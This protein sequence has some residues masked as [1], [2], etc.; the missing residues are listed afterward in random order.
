MAYYLLHLLFSVVIKSLLVLGSMSLVGRFI[1]RLAFQVSFSPSFS[2]LPSWS[3]IHS[4][5]IPIYIVSSQL[6]DRFVSGSVRS[7]W[8]H[9]IICFH[10]AWALKRRSIPYYLLFRR[11]RGL[12]S[13]IM[14]S[15]ARF[16]TTLLAFLTLLCAFIFFLSI[17]YVFILWDGRRI[18]I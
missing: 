8:I 9:I 11:P 6:R 1:K 10:S 16:T 17:L 12:V 18:P 7:S 2:G 14:R 13:T 15:C 4:K 3:C 5:P